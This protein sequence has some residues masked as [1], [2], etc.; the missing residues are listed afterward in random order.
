MTICVPSLAG[1]GN[2]TNATGENILV[3]T[4][5][6]NGVGYRQ[7]YLSMSHRTCSLIESER[8]NFGYL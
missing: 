8:N 2:I 4:N 3:M 6:D 7:A 1:V 5:T